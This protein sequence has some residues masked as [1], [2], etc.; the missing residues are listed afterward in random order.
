MASKVL[1]NPFFQI[2]SPGADGD[3]E[4]MGIPN[5][6][7]TNVPPNGGQELQSIPGGGSGLD[8]GM[9]MDGGNW[10]FFEGQTVDQDS[11]ITG[12]LDWAPADAGGDAVYK[13]RGGGGL[14]GGLGGGYGGLPDGG[15]GITSDYD[16]FINGQNDEHGDWPFYD[17]GSALT[18]DTD[19]GLGGILGDRVYNPITHMYESSGDGGGDGNLSDAGGGN[20]IDS[21]GGAGADHGGQNKDGPANDYS[22]ADNGAGEDHPLSVGN[23]SND[24]GD[25]TGTGTIDGDVY[26]PIEGADYGREN[27]FGD[28]LDSLTSD[29]D[30]YWV[31]QNPGATSPGDEHGDVSDTTVTVKPSNQDFDQDAGVN[32]IPIDGG[33]GDW[34]ADQDRDGL[35]D[36]G[37][38]GDK[39]RNQHYTDTG[40]CELQL[41]PDITK[42]ITTLTQLLGLLQGLPPAA[43]QLTSWVGMLTGVIGAASEI[44]NGGASALTLLKVAMDNVSDG[45]KDKAI[46]LTY[47]LWDE[48]SQS[49]QEQIRDAIWNLTRAGWNSAFNASLISQ[50]PLDCACAVFYSQINN[51]KPYPGPLSRPCGEAHRNPEP[52]SFAI[53]N[54][55]VPTASIGIPTSGPSQMTTIHPFFVLT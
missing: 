46:D 17:H 43:Y 7:L 49:W 22:D 4:T 14:G 42:A 13:F 29:Y 24:G 18:S 32:L 12:G 8:P 37:F 27:G 1:D 35:A 40:I 21:D 45:V 33:G 6:G 52:P 11:Q 39:T 9:D 30:Y 16:Q 44:A 36:P 34:R 26:N 19:K 5:P 41:S 3:F 38:L 51:G 10:T 15:P 25:S 2:P 54:I 20:L 47:E 50:T 31:L 53:K 55:L 23:G 28:G 48:Y